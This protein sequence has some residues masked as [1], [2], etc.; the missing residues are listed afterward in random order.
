MGK[1][2]KNHVIKDNTICDIRVHHS[3]E[4]TAGTRRLRGREMGL[5]ACRSPKGN[6]NYFDFSGR[7]E[8]SLPRVKC[9]KEIQG[10]SILVRVFKNSVWLQSFKFSFTATLLSLQIYFCDNT[11]HVDP[12]T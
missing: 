8:L 6:K 10:K 7:F 11:G 2:S 3:G 9:V 12:E 1:N 5:N 4:G